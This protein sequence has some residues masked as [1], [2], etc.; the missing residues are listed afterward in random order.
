MQGNVFLNRVGN[1]NKLGCW[2]LKKRNNRTVIL[3]TLVVVETVLGIRSR[4]DV[5]IGLQE[6]K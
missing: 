3:S 2:S 1:P 4:H 5:K 6:R